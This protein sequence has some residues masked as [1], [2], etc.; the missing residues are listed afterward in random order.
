VYTLTFGKHFGKTF[1]EVEKS[2]D[3]RYIIDLL[4]SRIFD[5]D[6]DMKKALEI[7]F[8][9]R[10]RTLQTSR[11]PTKSTI[12]DNGQEHIVEGQEYVVKYVVPFGINKGHRL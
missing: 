9:A 5:K 4:I 1:P 6:K 7:F 2:G 8:D 3:Y 11:T 10:K 12:D